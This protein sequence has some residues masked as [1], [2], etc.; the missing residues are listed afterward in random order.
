MGPITRFQELSDREIVN[1]RIVNTLTGPMGLQTMTQVQS[2]T[3]SEAVKGVDVLAQAKTGT[4]KTIGFLLPVLQR[5]LESKPELADRRGGMR[6]RY[7]AGRSSTLALIISPTRELAEQIATEA[8]R[9]TEGTGVLVQT[10]VGGTQKRSHLNDMVRQ[11]CHI[12][13]GTPGRLKDLLSSDIEAPG[14]ESLVLDEADRLMDDGFWPEIKDIMSLLPDT[15]TQDR[16]TL[17][18]SATVPP[19]VVKLARSVL[20]RDMHYVRTVQEDETPT[21]ER[22]KQTLVPIPGFENSLPTVL[23]ILEKSQQQNDFIPDGRPFKAIVYFNSTAE[24]TLNF[25]LLMHL[26][27]NPHLLPPSLR[28]SRLLKS[29][30]VHAIHSRLTQQQRTNAAAYFREARSAILCSSDVTARGMDF[31]GVTHVIQVGLP[32]SRDQY[33][34]RLGRTA[35]AGKEGEGWLLLPQVAM[36]EMRTRLGRIPMDTVRPNELSAA[37]LDTAR[38]PEEESAEEERA[39]EDPYMQACMAAARDALQSGAIDYESFEKAYMGTIGTW[40]WFPNKSM[41]I[42]LL[43]RWARWGWGMM[44][45]PTISR[46]LAS[47]IGFFGIPGVNL[48]GYGN[49]RGD[50]GRAGDR[51]GGFG[52]GLG[53]RR[54]GF[55]GGFGGGERRS[56]FGDGSDRRGGFGGSGGGYGGDRRGGGGFGDRGGFGRSGGS[57]FENQGRTRAPSYRGGRY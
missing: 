28:D 43:N 49:R 30:R 53:E 32:P 51:E 44:T 29:V 20:K 37:S 41:T 50:G 12:L 40:Q 3:I 52:G 56:G 5:I 8:K 6:V 55:S 11:G 38:I 2:L 22:V 23:Q 27:Q 46:G 21:Q 17:L 35:R 18:F 7:G 1:R 24:T 4:G 36:R 33:V 39:L 10:A 26:R 54:G 34:H 13:V 48:D 19:D 57:G 9:L 47:R 25:H 45:P 42:D 14:L 31:P 16:Q 15:Q